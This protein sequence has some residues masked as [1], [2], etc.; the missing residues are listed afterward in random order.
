MPAM[1]AV[2]G[3]VLG[4]LLDKQQGHEVTDKEIYRSV[5]SHVAVDAL[6]CIVDATIACFSCCLCDL[7]FN[8]A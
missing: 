8:L 7:T 1:L 2:A 4:E 6:L 3:D 5:R